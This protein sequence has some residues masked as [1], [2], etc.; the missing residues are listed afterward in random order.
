MSLEGIEPS[1]DILRQASPLTFNSMCW[2]V[3]WSVKGQGHCGTPVALA[4]YYRGFETVHG[5]TLA[6]TAE[7]FCALSAYLYG[8]AWKVQIASLTETEPSKVREMAKGKRR[9]SPQIATHLLAEMAA[10]REAFEAVQD[11][12]EEAAN[13]FA[14]YVQATGELP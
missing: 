12:L 8:E 3:V 5:K 6:M 9:V 10:D 1:R 11:I 4:L 14:C 2:L 7:H 13:Q